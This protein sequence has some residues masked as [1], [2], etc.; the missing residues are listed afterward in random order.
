MKRVNRL[1]LK[2]LV[3]FS[4]IIGSLYLAPF[5]EKVENRYS[6]VLS[7]LHAVASLQKLLEGRDV[8]ADNNRPADFDN[9]IRGK[10]TAFVFIPLL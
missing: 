4:N 1:V 10:V 8:D 9:I 3:Q 5:S 7:Y 6:K 2:F